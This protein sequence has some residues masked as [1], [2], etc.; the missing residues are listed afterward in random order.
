MEFS[1]KIIGE[2]IKLLRT[3]RGLLAKEIAGY[4]GFAK[5]SISQIEHGLHAPELTTLFSLA[6]YFD[7]SVDY[8]L[9][10]TDKREINR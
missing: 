6:N 4:L 10:R 7:V 1:K 9:G 3:E 8:I 2:R 5:S